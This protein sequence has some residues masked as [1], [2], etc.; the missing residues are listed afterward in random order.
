MSITVPAIG[1][2]LVAL[3]VGTAAVVVPET[4]S[5]ETSSSE[6]EPSAANHESEIHSTDIIGWH[7]PLPNDTTLLSLKSDGN[8][9]DGQ[10]EG[11]YYVDLQLD[12]A[13]Y[14]RQ[15]GL[16]LKPDLY[17]E[18]VGPKPQDLS[19]ANNGKPTLTS[20]VVS[21]GTLTP[22]FS[23]TVEEYTVPD[24]PYGSQ[25]F[26]IST[27][28][29]TGIAVNFWQPFESTY[30][31]LEDL[32]DVA[33]G[34]QISLVVG[35][36][37]VEVSLSKG[38]LYRDYRLL[39]T[40]AK[41][42]VSIRALSTGPATEGDTLRFEIKRSAATTETL[43]VRVAADEL[44]AI[45]GKV[46]D[47]ILPNSIED[48]SPLYHI[49]ADQ[50]VAIVEIETTDD[51]KWE[52]HSKIEM[53]IVAD[54]SYSIDSEAGVATTVV[55]DD[56][57]LASEAVL[58]AAPNPV[59]EG[60]GNTVVTVTVTTEGN[61][62]PH[63]QVT[64]PVTT[65]AGT[66]TGGADYTE[67]DTALT[68]SESDFSQVEIDGNSHYIAIKTVDISIVPDTLDE[69]D[70]SFTVS[71]GAPSDS[72]VSLDSDSTD[73]SVTIVDDDLTVTQPILTAVTIGN[74]S[75]TPTFSS[76]QLFY[77]II[78]ATYGTHLLTITTTPETGATASLLDSSDNTLD[79]LD[80][81]MDGHQVYLAIGETTVKVRVA[82][83]SLSQDYTFVITRARPEISIRSVT[84][85]PATEG[86]TLKFELRRSLAAGDVLTVDVTISELGVDAESDPGD[87]FPDAEEGVSLS[88]EIALD[89]ST[90]TVEV[91][92][93]DDNTWENHSNIEVKILEGDSYTINPESGT[94]SVIVKDNEIVE[95]EA[96]L[97][98]SPNPISEDMVKAIATITVTTKGE[99]GPHGSITIPLTTSD[100]A[101]T[102]GE[103]YMEIDTTLTF[104]ELHFAQIDLDGNSR[105]RAFKTVDISIVQDIIDEDSE[106]FSVAL[107]TPSDDLVTLD[108]GSANTSVAITDDD[109]PPIL[110][111]LS[112][113]VG[114]LTPSF[115][116]NQ[117][118]YDIP[119]VGYG[120]HVITI[121]ATPESGVEASFLD[122][123]NDPYDDLDDMVDGHQVYLEIGETTLTVRVVR[124][125]LW[126]DYSLAITRAK[127]TVSIRTLSGN[128]ATEGDILR[129]Q[130]ERDETA[131]DTLEVR[132][133]MDELDVIVGQGHGDL[134]SD[135]IEGTSPLREIE[136]GTNIAVFT[137]ETV[138][139]TAWEKHS[140]VEMRIKP[141]DWYSIDSAGAIAT[142][143]VHDD[144]FPEAEA[145][146][147]VSPNPVN[148][149]T[150]K[151][152]A[153]ITVTTAY[154]T[155]PHGQVAIPLTTSDG[156]AKAGEDYVA[157]KESLVLAEEDFSAIQLDGNTLYQ[158]TEA[159]DIMLAQDDV[160]ESAESFNV[161][162]GQP[163]QSV[164]GIDSDT[165]IVSVLIDDDD[166]SKP[167]VTITTVPS[168]ASVLGRGVVN[169]DGESSDSN[170]DTLTYIWST[171]PAIIG[172][173]GDANLED[174][175]WTAP[176]S[177]AEVQT[178]TLTLTV[179]DNGSPQEQGTATATVTVEAN[180]APL[181]EASASSGTVQGDGIIELTGGGSDPEQGVLTYRWS[182]DGAFDNPSAKDTLW[183]APQATNQDQMVILTL[184]VTDELGLDDT[185]TV[186]IIVSAMND[187]PS[188]PAS[189]TGE[190]NIGEGSGAGDEVGEPVEAVDEDGDRL[191][192]V[193]GGTDASSFEIDGAGQ[194][195]VGSSTTLDY[196]IKGS[197]AVTVSV[198]DGKDVYGNTDSSVDDVKEATIS[199]VD[200]EEEGSVSLSPS[201]PQVGEVMTASVT[202]PDNYTPLDN[203]GLILPS[204]VELWTW[205]RSDNSDGPWMTIATRSTAGYSPV[206]ADKGQFLRATAV[207][208]DRRGPA[209]TASEVSWVVSPGIPSAPTSLMTTYD[210]DVNGL[211]M[212]WSPPLSDGGDPITEYLVQWRP[213]IG[214]SCPENGGWQNVSGPGNNEGN[215]ECATVINHHTEASTTYTITTL[216]STSL[217]AGTT[218][219]VR[220]SAANAMGIGGW[221][222]VVSARA[223]S[224]D[225]T[226]NSLTIGPVDISEFRA[227]TMFYAL[228]VSGAVAQATV[229]ATTA[230][231]NATVVFSPPVD[232][233]LLR[234]G[235]QID[236]NPGDTVIAVT[237]TAENGETTRT[238]TIIIT[239][240]MGNSA[241]TISVSPDLAT[242]NGYNGVSL[243]GT[244][245][246]LEKDR[247]S[248]SWTASVDIGHFE[249]ESREDTMWIAPAP[250]E[251]AQTVVLTLTV[252]DG[253]GGR[254][255]DRVVVTVNAR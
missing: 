127:P 69:G 241:P 132:V 169:L 137:V 15:P 11:H 239:R 126:Q 119:D 118:S 125:A 188:F 183:T 10:D 204:A 91:E 96:V 22:A 61:I 252:R 230:D 47:D 39:I 178:I 217:V 62:L 45:A 196:E 70:E 242:V 73:L 99:K 134:L 104:S 216:D 226:L 112:L 105:Y 50:S 251:V 53:E 76:N 210:R 143:V 20:L 21:A 30:L 88:Y 142:I 19:D 14:I 195:V 5:G 83:G 156:S 222:E 95:A 2:A 58:T 66:A 187:A 92:T 55:R 218:Y 75:L 139:D 199:V 16:F 38:D 68:F 17:G 111:S 194:I 28:A 229:S 80:D 57:F 177:L 59:G 35:E 27:V 8:A 60:D 54:D 140:K 100:G 122:S 246:D 206:V 179:N 141:E 159:V 248:Y 174:T 202:D 144:D 152:S 243:N 37:A 203:L 4:V 102:S 64:I 193:L 160:E 235:H 133:G 110:T 79:D 214:P 221:S 115:S 227:G 72:L 209:K 253:K 29:E 172:E 56:E 225:A 173:F 200:V 44:D 162:M 33:D 244:S 236:L 176:A 63:G 231:S 163:S 161:M 42:T 205:E 121:A 167:T 238:Y 164:V 220:V 46:H 201:S 175:T 65:S 224:A 7:D 184:T 34:H 148:E 48:D 186:Q 93:T 237:V 247:L 136:A 123:N 249:D 240:V 87:L 74:E 52:N 71:L 49:E 84:T 6:T 181:A 85:G 51:D 151:T 12:Q 219:D 197:Y 40:R 1:A 89:E 185:D 106:S 180:Q 171:T 155:M 255:T 190:R 165:S 245:S 26:T 150:S 166:N 9:P 182:G 13:D 213:T 250:R 109:G 129:F 157:L 254:A 82:K 131:G 90:A 101:A 120:T 43:A 86:D 189:E 212:S 36:N 211:V 78:D 108:T 147:S 31:E 130:I 168:P 154:A 41:P 191:I 158:A 25:G 228:T 3:I 198:S 103:D 116:S 170:N 24:V 153:T 107:G 145:V 192:Y 135:I 233:N 97:H 207:Y 149:G 18:G 77:E 32:D 215:G 98:V 232:S 138:P 234:E 146:L 114:T 67:L 208:S 23:G 223:P 117:F 113:S 81:A 94:A 124:G 128:P